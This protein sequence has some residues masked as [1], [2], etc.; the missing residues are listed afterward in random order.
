MTSSF[1][2]VR[3]TLA[4]L[5]FACASAHVAARAQ[6]A[7]KIDEVTRA[8]CDLGEVPQVTD[9]GMPV[10][11]A[12]AGQPRARVAVVVYGL[13][14]DAI[15]YAR[16]VG[17]WLTEARAVASERLLDVYGG[18]AQQRRLELWLVPEG[19]APPTAAPPAADGRVTLFDKYSYW[20]GEYCGPDRPPALNVF[21]ETLKRMPGWRGTI[22]VRP[23]VNR[24]GSRPGDNDWDESPLTRRG[25]MRRAAEDR[26]H[27]V[28]QLGIDPARIRAVVGPDD[29]W[30]HAELWL[31]PPAAA[32]PAG[33]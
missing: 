25:A 33:R 28:R 10:F 7:Y 32:T 5:L 15:V 22:V 31:I 14:G 27:L 6:Q 29:N 23:H 3:R 12:L 8:R 9:P 13:P 17:H 11:V 1:R 18:P 24:R 20:P 16:E 19:A 21:A 2:S 26:L 4:L 30:A